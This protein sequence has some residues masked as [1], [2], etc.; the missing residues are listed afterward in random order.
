VCDRRL[1]GSLFGFEYVWEL[2]VPAAK[3]RWGW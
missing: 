2:F 1:L 3:R